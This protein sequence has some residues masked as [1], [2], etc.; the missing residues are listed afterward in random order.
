LAAACIECDDNRYVSPPIPPRRK[1]VN[2]APAFGDA[3]IVEIDDLLAAL[4]EPLQPPDVCALDG[5][6]AGAALQR[7]PLAEAQWLPFVSD[8]QGRAAPPGVALARLHALARRRFA[9]LDSRIEQRQWFDPWVFE[10]S[11]AMSPSEAVTPWIAG[12]ALALDR[13]PSFAR[14]EP[15]AMLEPLAAL[16][17]HLDPDDLEDADELL[18]QIEMLEPARDLGEAVEDLVR[19]TLL[20]ADISRP[21]RAESAAARTP[22]RTAA[23]GTRRRH[24]SR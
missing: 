14:A 18:A 16:Y 21:R 11:D 9:E 23:G 7:P 17:R 2:V 20:L 1:R 5:F 4:P 19:A 22:G 24:A 6:L 10:L 8:T 12:F 13:F 3:E 15:A